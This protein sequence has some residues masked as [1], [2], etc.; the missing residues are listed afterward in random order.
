MFSDR[1]PSST[2]T[3]GVPALLPMVDRLIAIMRAGR[4]GAAKP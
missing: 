2:V 4:V 1:A 3:A